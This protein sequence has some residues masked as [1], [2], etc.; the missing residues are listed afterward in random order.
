M[1]DYYEKPHQRATRSSP[2]RIRFRGRRLGRLG[3]P[4]RQARRPRAVR[5]RRPAW[6]PTRHVWPRASSSAPPTP[7]W[8]SSTRSAPLTE[9]LDAIELATTQRLH[10]PWFPTAPARPRTP[11]S[12]TWLWPRTPARSRPVPPLAGERIAKYN[13]LLRIEERAGRG[14]RLPRHGRVLASSAS[15]H[16]QAQAGVSGRQPRRMSLWRRSPRWRGFL[17]WVL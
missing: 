13:Q 16:G 8:S 14:R 9:T 7:C 4:H 5:R 1:L 12:P 3:G 11:P 10:L 17:R 2:S 15:R 6:S